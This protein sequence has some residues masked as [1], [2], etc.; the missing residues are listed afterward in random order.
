VLR[1]LIESA[2]L[3]PAVGADPLALEFEV[4]GI[5]VEPGRDGGGACDIGIEWE[6]QGHGRCV[7]EMRCAGASMRARTHRWQA[8]TLVTSVAAE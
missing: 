2:N 4:D 1:N 8:V 5:V 7:R 6:G 3:L